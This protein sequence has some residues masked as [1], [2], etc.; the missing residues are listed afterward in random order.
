MD[1]RR[2][3]KDVKR[4]GREGEYKERAG[5]LKE[6]ASGKVITAES[7]YITHTGNGSGLL[8]IYSHARR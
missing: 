8:Y 4:R 6:G 2:G 3:R 5:R 7:V 1:V